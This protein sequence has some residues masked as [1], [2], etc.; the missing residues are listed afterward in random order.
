MNDAREKDTVRIWDL[1]TRLFKWALAVLVVFQVTTGLLA[2]S[3]LTWHFRSGYAIL[4]LLIF[5]ILWG[6]VG[7][8]TSRFSSFLKGPYAGLAHVRELLGSR[9][10]R[11]LGHNAVGGWVVIVIILALLV[12]AGS[13]LF[14][15]DDIA[16]DGPLVAVASERW[17]KAMTSL[18]VRWIL[19]IYILIGLHVLAA[20]LYLIVK[21]QNL[22][23]AMIT[24]R[25]RRDDVVAPDQPLPAIRFAGNVSA[26]ICLAVAAAVVYAILRFAS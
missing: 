17:V 4:T 14:T 24:G 15:T 13:G 9:G 25:K 2:G 3:W 16:T 10:P 7:S 26:L 11:E 8:T 21:K 5:R 20:V 12:Q 19:V 23:L 22:I 18:H 1:P 6:I